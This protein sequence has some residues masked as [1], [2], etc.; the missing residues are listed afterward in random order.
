MTT[1]TV[2]TLVAS[3]SL[4]AAAACSAGSESSPLVSY[5]AGTTTTKDAGTTT[6]DAGTPATLDGGAS[7]PTS[8]VVVNEVMLGPDWIELKNVGATIADLSGWHVAD[9]ASGAGTGPKATEH[10]V[11]PPNTKIGP[12]GYLLIRAGQSLDAGIT[13]TACLDG[14]VSFC[15]LASFGLSRSKGD[16]VY[17]LKADESVSDSTEF[18]ANAVPAGSAWARLPDGTGSFALTTTPTAFAANR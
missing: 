12:G 6:Q 1:A 17:L 13:D 14:G 2:R 15:F 4:A 11:F 5:D 9:S 7:N 10:L 16:G 18:G 8:G 3:L